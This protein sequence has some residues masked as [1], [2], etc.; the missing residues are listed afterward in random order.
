VNGN[1]T[2]TIKAN[3]A[4]VGSGSS[5]TSGDAP[6]LAVYADT[7]SATYPDDIKVV[8]VSSGNALQN[9]QVNHGSLT[10]S[11]TATGNP[12]CGTVSGAV[13]V[14]GNSQ[15]IRKTVPTFATV[16]GSTNLFVGQ[17]TLYSFSVT[18]GSNAN[19][20]IHKFTVL[21]SVSAGATANTVA[22]YENGSLV[23]PSKYSVVNDGGVSLAAT[24]AN[25]GSGSSH[26]MIFTFAGEDKI[27]LNS[28]KT[29]AIKA[30]VTAAAAASSISTY[31]VSD[32]ATNA[33]TYTPVQLTIATTNITHAISVGDQI[34]QTTSTATGSV[35]SVTVSGS[36]T[37]IDV[38]GVTSGPFVTTG[39]YTLNDNTT[40]LLSTSTAPSTVGT[41]AAVTYGSTGTIQQI[42]TNTSKNMIWSDNSASLHSAGTHVA[43][44]ADIYYN[45][46]SADW[47]NGYLVQTL[48]S[49]PQSLSN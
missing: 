48:P 26:T 36:N 16:A 33:T 31:M 47:T 49:T 19:V 32:V 22:L 11:S 46:S 27:G 35:Y 17:N 9:A 28:T 6:K 39:G 30:N 25:V 12:A 24:A 43:G 40:V 5:A 21:S 37:L 13:C 4:Q 42:D 8:G 38:T 29:F 2:I 3:I 14:G 23:D 7:G 1:M 10:F 41:D 18:A 20:A 34:T 44:T 15:M 45:D